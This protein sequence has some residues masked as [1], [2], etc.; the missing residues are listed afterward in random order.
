MISSKIQLLLIKSEYISHPITKE[1][2]QSE[3]IIQNPKPNF[4]TSRYI[5]E[6]SKQNKENIPAKPKDKTKR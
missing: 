1:H 6:D 3:K 2:N 5:N 4:E